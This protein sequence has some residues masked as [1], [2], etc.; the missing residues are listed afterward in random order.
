MVRG[1]IP[2]PKIVNI[3]SLL[4]MNW[5]ETDSELSNIRVPSVCR[6]ISAVSTGVLMN[7]SQ[8]QSLSHALKAVLSDVKESDVTFKHPFNM[9]CHDLLLPG[10]SN[11]TT[12]KK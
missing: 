4:P 3:R 12:G 6:A 5:P 2:R 7:E 10:P 8:R 1:V 11:I 9:L